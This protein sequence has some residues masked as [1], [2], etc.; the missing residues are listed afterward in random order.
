[1]SEHRI[2]LAQCTRRALLKHLQY[3]PVLWVPSPLRALVDLKSL[4]GFPLG[5]IQIIPHYPAGSPLDDM[6]RLVPSGADGYTTEVH[7]FGIEGALR[8]W[9]RALTSG[10][11]N[12]VLPS[13]VD[14][15]LLAASPLTTTE[16]EVYN[17]YGIRATRQR[18]SADLKLGRDHFL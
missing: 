14:G 5:E 6:L 4:P 18:C 12:E 7:A 11:P 3:A 16:V 17:H 2:S 13:L 8:D 1:M 10:S 9:G 15:S